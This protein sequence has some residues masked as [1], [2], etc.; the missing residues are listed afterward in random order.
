MAKL[1]RIRL[2][3]ELEVIVNPNQEPWQRDFLKPN[4]VFQVKEIPNPAAPGVVWL[5]VIGTNMAT[6]LPM[7]QKAADSIQEV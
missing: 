7:W 1:Y 5:Q 2:K 4:G 3:Q 6:S